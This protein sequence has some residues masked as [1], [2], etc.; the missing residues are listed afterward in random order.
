[1]YILVHTCVYKY[2]LYVCGVCVCSFE[3]LQRK[4]LTVVTAVEVRS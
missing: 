1:M 2:T 3:H 4:L